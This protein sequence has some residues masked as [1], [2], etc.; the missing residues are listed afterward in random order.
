MTR[1]SKSQTA[2]SK[3]S[4]ANKRRHLQ[5]MATPAEMT[6]KGMLDAHPL[7]AGRF[8][9]QAAVAGYFPD[10]S[11][12]HCK[13]IVEVDGACHRGRAA[14]AADARRTAKLRAKGWKV[15]RFWNSEL[16]SPATVMK[17][18]LTAIREDTDY[19]ED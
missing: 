19:Y 12:R 14:Q 5:S 3:M 16:K 8:V 1:K 2:W 4:L 9:H 17:A 10:F 18:I 15:I 11:F 13:L 7:T 6:L